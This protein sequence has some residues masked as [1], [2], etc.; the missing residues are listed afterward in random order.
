MEAASGIKWINKLPETYSKP[1]QTSKI[2]LWQKK[3][4]D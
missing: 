1:S 4:S 2:N 3:V